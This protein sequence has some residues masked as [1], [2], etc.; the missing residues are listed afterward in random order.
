MQLLGMTS[1]FAQRDRLRGTTHI[2]SAKDRTDPIDA[3][4]KRNNHLEMD[5]NREAVRIMPSWRY[6]E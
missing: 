2:G 3:E 1:V 6:A 5:D 4:I